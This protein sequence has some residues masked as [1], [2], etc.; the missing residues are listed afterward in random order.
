MYV[1]GSLETFGGPQRHAIAHLEAGKMVIPNMSSVMLGNSVLFLKFQYLHNIRNY[2]FLAGFNPRPDTVF[3]HLRSDRR[4]LVRPPLGVSKRSVVE[5][6]GKTGR[7]LSQSTRDWW[8]YF[9]S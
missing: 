4:G 1:H 3:R 9:W 7:L 5:L 8:Y 6:N 2:F